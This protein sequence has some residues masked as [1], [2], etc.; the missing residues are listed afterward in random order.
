MSQS[1]FALT[2]KPL[3]SGYGH[4]W[5]PMQLVATEKLSPIK[6]NPPM[7]TP[8]HFDPSTLSICDDPIPTHRL[9][10]DGKYKAIFQKLKVGQ[11]LKVNS[12]HTQTVAGSLRTF[13]A[14][15]HAV[16]SVKDYGDGMGRVW[17]IDLPKKTKKVPA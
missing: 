5:P 13:V 4:L 3:P 17:L 11:A 10:V 9:I 1:S 16:K 15:K 7:K 14:G 12:K 6:A 2:T 8:I